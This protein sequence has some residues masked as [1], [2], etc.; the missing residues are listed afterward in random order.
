MGTYTDNDNIRIESMYHAFVN[1][2]ING[3]LKNFHTIT[4]T[5]TVRGKI[6]RKF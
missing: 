5:C 6:N 4:A 1:E 3:N 2:F